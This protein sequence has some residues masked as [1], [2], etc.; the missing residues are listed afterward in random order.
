[1]SENLVFTVLCY[2]MWHRVALENVTYDPTEYTAYIFKVEDYVK[3]PE[4]ELY[5][6]GDS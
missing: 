5:S 4:A 3:Q 2:G 6:D 1:M